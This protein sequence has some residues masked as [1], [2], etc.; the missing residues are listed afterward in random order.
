MEDVK[1]EEP[2][3]AAGLMA[4]REYR[5]LKLQLEEIITNVLDAGSVQ[6]IKKYI[7]YAE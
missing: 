1:K 2:V 3:K 7:L 5:S 4:K 6:D